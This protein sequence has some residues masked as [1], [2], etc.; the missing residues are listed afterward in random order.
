MWRLFFNRED[1]MKKF[2]Y[3][4]LLLVCV[5]LIGC[6]KS[7]GENASTEPIT[8][9]QALAAVKN[10]CHATNPDLQ[11]IEDAGNYPVYWDVESVG[12][13]EI[14]VLFRSYTAAQV[15][16]YI[17]PTTGETY[18]TEFMPGISEEEE[19]TDVTFNIRDYI[20]EGAENEPEEKNDTSLVPGEYVREFV[21]E[22]D[23][24]EVTC[25]ESFVLNADGTG[26][27]TAQDTVKVKWDEE[28]IFDDSM[29]FEYRV[30][31]KIL[32]VKVENEWREFKR[33]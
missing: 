22:I 13:N 10:Y 12:D 27:Y 4:L 20:V 19:S 18:V 23:G 14:V 26:T 7:E 16:Y 21:E 15:R 1:E 6:G 5:L 8:E 24:T 17:N 33:K 30:D 3:A 9:E 31:K 11:G 29:E 2:K 32:R 28:K 25:T